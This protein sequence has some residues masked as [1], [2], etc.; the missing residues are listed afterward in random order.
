MDTEE[1]VLVVANPGTG[2][3]TRLASRVVELIQ[4]GA[5]ESE[6]LCITFTNKAAQEMRS[7]IVQIAKEKGVDIKISDLAV[8]TFHS[9]ALEY[10]QNVDRDYKVLGN[11]AL[12]FSIFKTFEK[13]KALNY[14]SDYIISD[15]VPK[16]ENAIRYVKSFGI[17]PEDIKI[18]EASKELKKIYE[19]EGISNVSLD[20]NLQFLKYFKEAYSN[21]ENSKNGEYIDYND[22]LLMFLK[23][24]DR[25]LKHYKHVL[26]DELQDVN[27]IEAQIAIKSGDML[28]LVGDRKQAI[29]GFQGGS[30]RNFDV[31]KVKKLES[32]SKNYRSKQRIL[33]YAKGHFSE[34]TEYD[35][36]KKELKDLGSDFDGGT[37]EVV[38]AEK[39]DNVAVKMAMK[40]SGKTAI[41]TRTNGQLLGI[42][43]ILDSKNVKYSSTISTATSDT[44]KKEIIKFLRGL[45]YESED[46]VLGALLTPF[47]GMTPQQAFS[48][49][50]KA[51][52]GRFKL[53]ADANAFFAIK[54]SIKN[55]G[56][57]ARLFETNILPISASIG[58]DFFIT[59]NAIAE[60]INEFLDTVERPD[61]E[62]LFNYL[63]IA[64]E[65]YEPIGNEGNL[66][67]SS[68]HKAKGLE[69]D[70]VIYVPKPTV[71]KFSFID[72]VVCAIIKSRL[73]IDIREELK[74]EELRIDFVAFTRAKSC[75]Y[76]I[77]TP[78]VQKRYAM[79]RYASISSDSGED[80]PEPASLNYDKAYSLFV[81]GNYGEAQKLLNS[82][83]KWLEEMIRNYFG[84]LNTFYFTLV[85]GI[86]D[87]YRFFKDY[88]IAMPH[89]NVQMG[90]G[91]RIHEIAELYFRGKL[92]EAKLEKD[93]LKYLANI[94]KVNDELSKYGFRQVAA[95]EK[96]NIGLN[97]LLNCSDDLTFTGKIDAIYAKENLYLIVDFKTDKSTDYN[98]DHRRQLAA[99]KR[100]YSIAKNVE[101]SSISTAIAYIGLAG[102]INTGR[103]DYSIAYEKEGSDKTLWA[104]FLKQ[105]Q[106]LLA[107]KSDPIKFI[108]ALLAQDKNELLFEIV[109]RELGQQS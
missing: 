40:M 100:L 81:A 17:L 41:I 67:I 93:E 35:E 96:L 90:L 63:A 16:T 28:F 61:R 47:S 51:N 109:K 10:L 82:R 4:K 66:L 68:V 80:E 102:K 58:K 12:R 89:R 69:F 37:V 83:E 1:S 15:I 72:A 94:K 33:D 52:S 79:D 91:S 49:I 64:E 55:L 56:D 24:Y 46:E 65:N 44:A 19:E 2:K 99:Y 38:V 11:N 59:A 108:E 30:V 71:E 14:P 18:E 84:K 5:K 105:M 86:K 95:E 8:H 74:E 60:N 50:E 106:L 53:E 23:R 92:D 6:I 21:Y 20:E 32:L 76:I 48:A 34:N 104:N 45:L 88:I 57:I 26:V 73:G 29:F 78:K 36:L 97:K 62:S 103:L 98:T 75:L 85:E 31:F 43:K 107:Y 101:Q 27:S 87:P 7:K 54:S 9:Y 25:N 13:L 39:P 77:T 3:T 42:S 22:M 70:N